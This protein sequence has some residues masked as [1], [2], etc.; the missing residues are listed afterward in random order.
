ME[1]SIA[2]HRDFQTHEMTF[3]LGR[4]EEEEGTLT[5]VPYG[6]EFS[7]H[8]EVIGRKPAYGIYTNGVFDYGQWRCP[9]GGF[10][11]P[12]TFRELR[13]LLVNPTAKNSVNFGG[14][15][16]SLQFR[17]ES[18]DYVEISGTHPSCEFGESETFIQL[19]LRCFTARRAVKQAAE[20]IT[21]LLSFVDELEQAE[22]Q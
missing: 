13:D 8:P 21:E 2:S 12:A 6:C 7:H 11:H 14:G 3:V 17:W 16:L 18:D 4:S 1:P 22:W 9:L 20:E 5:L 10:I 19:N 15:Y